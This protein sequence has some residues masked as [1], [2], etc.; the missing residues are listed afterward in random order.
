[1]LSNSAIFYQVGVKVNDGNGAVSVS[2]TPTQSLCDGKFHMVT[3]MHADITQTSSY[4]NG[5]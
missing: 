4:M 5:D 2:V 3:G 1:M